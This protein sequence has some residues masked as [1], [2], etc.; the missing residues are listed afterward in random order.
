MKTLHF[1]I[2]IRAPK[3]KVWNVML[4]QETY[5]IWTTPFMAG[6]YYEGSWE[7]GAKIKFLAAGSTDGMSSEIAE[8]KPFEFVSIKHVGFIKDG[9]EDTESS[10]IKAWAPLF[11][12]YTFTEHG[13]VTE[14]QVDLDVAPDFEKDMQEMWPKALESLKKL[15]E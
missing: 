10:Q 8:N 7:K 9:I 15:C 3:E 12:N 14:V 6:S 4:N 5:K 2:S 13:G 11:E 1:A